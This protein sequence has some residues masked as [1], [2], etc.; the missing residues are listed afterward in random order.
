ME[1][2]TKP[3]RTCQNGRFNLEGDPS[4]NGVIQP[5]QISVMEWQDLNLAVDLEHGMQIQPSSDLCMNGRIQ[6]TGLAWKLNSRTYF[7]ELP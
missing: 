6:P 1:L 2:Q 7:M 4:T 3:S 5:K